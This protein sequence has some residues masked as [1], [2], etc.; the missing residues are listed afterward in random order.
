MKAGQMSL[1]AAIIFSVLFTLGQLF[2]GKVFSKSE[3]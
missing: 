1:I 2:Y 3:A